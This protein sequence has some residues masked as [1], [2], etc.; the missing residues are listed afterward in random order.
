MPY[1]VLADYTA[2][3]S[4]STKVI[5][6]TEFPYFERQAEG[7]LNR[8]IG[9]LLSSVSV[10]GTVAT[11]TID[12]V[13]YALVLSDLKNCICEISEFLY[14]YESTINKSSGGLMSSYSNDGQAGSF[15]NAGIN[16]AAKTKE[17]R[18]IAKKYLSGTI[19]MNQGVGMWHG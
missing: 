14:Q 17:I 7:E 12:D 5:S 8:Q 10:V 18:G 6:D 3:R 19:L 16:A 9:G 4:G 13:A 11:I 2:Y 15:N 1:V